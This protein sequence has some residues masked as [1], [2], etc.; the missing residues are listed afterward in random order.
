MKILPFPKLRLRVVISCDVGAREAKCRGV[1]ENR[2]SSETD[3][4]AEHVT[5][6]QDKN[7]FQFVQADYKPGNMWKIMSHAV[8]INR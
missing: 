7:A 5:M 8:C 4:I 6:G 2:P 1:G 3:L